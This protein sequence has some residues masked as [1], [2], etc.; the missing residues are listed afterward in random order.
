VEINDW[1]VP[2]VYTTGEEAEVH[3]PQH[4]QDSGLVKTL[5]VLEENL[6]STKESFIRNLEILSFERQLIDSGLIFLH[7]PAG[8]G[9]TAMIQEWFICG[10]MPA[11]LSLVST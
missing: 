10:E 1:I 11:L 5:G 9:K 6:P 2:V 4:V 3:I 7:G 8:S